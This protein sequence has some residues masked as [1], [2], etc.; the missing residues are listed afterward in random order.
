MPEERPTPSPRLTRPRGLWIISVG[1]LITAAANVVTALRALQWGAAYAASGVTFPP[2]LP[3]ITGL[4]WAV[5]CGWSAWRLWRLRNGAARLVLLL[6]GIYALYQAIWWRV[7]IRA[8]YARQRWPFA[9]LMMVLVWA[10]LA[11]YLQRPRVRA[12]FR[13]STSEDQ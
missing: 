1:L 2:L 12:L 6:L 8:D 13:G 10:A 7:F 11:W 3:V 5:A 4:G 9:V